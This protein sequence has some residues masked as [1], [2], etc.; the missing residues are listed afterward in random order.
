MDTMQKS[1]MYVPPFLYRSAYLDYGKVQWISCSL[2]QFFATIGGDN[3]L[4]IWL[5]DSSQRVTKGRRFRCVY[6]QSPPNRV[7]YVSFGFKTINSDVWLALLTHDGS[8]TLFEPADPESFS[9]WNQIDQL[10]P[11]GQHHR[12]TEARFRMSFHRSENP[13]A[14][15]LLAGLEPRAMSLAVSAMN[16]VKI[17]RAVKPEENL[18]GNYQCYEML[19]IDIHYVL[20]NE[21]AWAPG[22]LH[23]FDVVAIAC[24]DGTV[25]IFHVDTPCAVKTDTRAMA[26]RPPQMDNSQTMQANSARKTPSGIGAGLAGMSRTTTSPQDRGNKMDIKHVSKEV[27]VLPHMEGSPVWKIRWLCDGK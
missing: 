21:I 12:G 17:F 15:A 24:D 8:L 5:E 4:K 13:S 9:S 10:F 7:S 26:V 25:R 19:H 14:N 6:S 18:E 20:I 1:W 11:F 27:A 3:K 16:I 22:C 23:P 2:G